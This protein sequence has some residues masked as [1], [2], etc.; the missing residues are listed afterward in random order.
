MRPMDKQ[1]H[2][3]INLCCGTVGCPILNCHLK[4]QKPKHQKPKHHPIKMQKSIQWLFFVAIIMVIPCCYSDEL[5]V[6]EESPVPDGIPL[7]RPDVIEMARAGSGIK[8][9]GKKP[10]IVGGQKWYLIE[11]GTKR[12]FQYEAFD[13]DTLQFK[14]KNHHY[15]ISKKQLITKLSK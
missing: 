2:P 11:R 7:D 12:K 6:S 13:E 5:T 15:G 8:N 14:Y 1:I 10:K 4:N 9:H 3:M